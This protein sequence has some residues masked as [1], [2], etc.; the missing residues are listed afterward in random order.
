[1]PSVDDPPQAERDEGKVP[2][3][4][5]LYDNVF[6]LLILGVVIMAV[7]YTGW[8]LWELIVMPAGSLP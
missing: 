8:G 1:M 3:G 6:L 2:L 7:V 5:R 4:Q